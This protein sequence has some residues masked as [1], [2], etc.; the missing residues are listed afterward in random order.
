MREIDSWQQ[1]DFLYINLVR[2]FLNQW[3]PQIRILRNIQK[4]NVC[5]SVVMVYQISARPLPLERAIFVVS[6]TCPIIKFHRLA[7]EISCLKVGIHVQIWE[8]LTKLDTKA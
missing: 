5:Q 4:Y 6:K 1:T 2:P 8:I 3:P 7:A